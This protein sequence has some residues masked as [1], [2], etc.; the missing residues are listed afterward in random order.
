[1]ARQL[2][3]RPPHQPEDQRRSAR[4][5]GH[6]RRHDRRR[7]A[8]RLPRRRKPTGAS[9]PRRCSSC[10]PQRLPGDFRSPC[11]APPDATGRGD[12]GFRS[13]SSRK[14][15]AGGTPASPRARSRT[16]APERTA[17]ATG[18]GTRSRCPAP[19]RSGTTRCTSWPERT[20]SCCSA[21]CRSSSA[22]TGPTKRPGRRAGRARRDWVSPSTAC[23][24]GATRASATS[25]IC[26]VSPAG[27]RAPSASASSGSTPCT[28]SATATRMPTARTCP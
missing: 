1:M 7:R 15:A 13:K 18:T 28:R 11:P 2:G 12:C 14:T 23:V 20:V 22:R 24:P 19:S 21:R 16:W 8:A 26:G 27:P 25:G 10:A 3:G 17:I 4:G 5:D 9:P 6:W